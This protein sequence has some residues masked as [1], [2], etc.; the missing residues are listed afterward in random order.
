MADITT[1]VLV[2]GAGPAGLTAAALLARQGTSS[3]TITKYRST[4][5]GPR[6]HITNQRTLE[7]L[8]DLGIELRVYEVGDKIV[9]VPWLVFVTS[10]AGQELSRRYAWGTR[11]DRRG[12]YRASSPCDNV[13]ISQH[14]LEPIIHHRAVELGADLRF[15][16][17]LIQVVQGSEGVTAKVVYRPTNHIYTIRARYL[18]GADGARSTV[19]EQVGIE[20]DGKTKLGYALNAHIEADLTHLTAH[21]PATLY[22]TNHPGRD[23]YFGSGIVALVRKWNEWMVQLSYSPETDNIEENDEAVMSRV[24]SAIGDPKVEIKIKNFGKWELNSLVAKQYRKGRVFIAGDAAHRHTPSGG[25]GSNTSIQDSYNLAWKLSAV[26]RGEAE[27]TLLDSYEAERLPVGRQVV[28]RATRSIPLVP[29]LAANLGIRAGQAEE[30]GW[31]A[32]NGLFE[33]TSEARSR[34]EALLKTLDGYDYGINCH[35]IEMGQRYESGAVVSDGTPFPAY[36]RDSELYYHP[37]TH[38]GAY[39]PHV[40]VIRHGVQISTLDLVP[41]DTWTVITGPEG[42]QWIDAT[43]QVSTELGLNIATAMIGLGLEISDLLGDWAEIREITDSGAL[44]IRPDKYIGW[45][46]FEVGKNSAAK[47]RSALKTLLH[48]D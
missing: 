26:L 14:L 28:D 1:D 24:R 34:R 21:R 19:A 5:N 31:A 18:V 30:D 2:V 23:Y 48:S 36:T 43:R 4:A 7:I 20:H 29:G 32:I 10:M 11:P 9:D 38:P 37:T 41:S 44:L 22:I 3:I 35:G 16:T 12:D 6:A 27:D 40:W 8:R 17:E 45:R 25:L 42:N 33:T 13:N 46:A 47:L 39:L 15:S